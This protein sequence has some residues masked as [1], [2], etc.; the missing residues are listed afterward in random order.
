MLPL[1]TLS[2]IFNLQAQ[3]EGC[4]CRFSNFRDGSDFAQ[5]RSAS[6]WQSWQQTPG[7]LQPGLCFGHE[8]ESPRRRWARCWKPLV[9]DPLPRGRQGL[10]RGPEAGGFLGFTLPALLA[11]GHVLT[12]KHGPA[13]PDAS[14]PFALQREARAASQRHQ[15]G[16]VQPARAEMHRL[17]GN[18]D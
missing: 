12:R 13:L 14:S 4:P 2:C 11:A 5:G 3:N 7:L 16:A 1:A 9:G 15:P 17:C 8:A 18:E 10:G 6:G